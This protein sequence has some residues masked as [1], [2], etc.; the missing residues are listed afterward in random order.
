M[1]RLLLAQKDCSC[2]ANT[3]G[4]LAS[5][6][7]RQ[8]IAGMLTQARNFARQRRGGRKTEQEELPT[9]SY[10]DGHTTALQE[11]EQLV[12]EVPASAYR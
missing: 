5:V 7:T 11:D 3:S 4:G 8:A 1:G 12:A 2:H 9:S 6:F 10:S